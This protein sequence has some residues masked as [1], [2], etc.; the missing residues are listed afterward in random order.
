MRNIALNTAQTDPSIK[1]SAPNVKPISELKD[2]NYLVI[3][4]EE[5]GRRIIADFFV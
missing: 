3:D 2:V 4:N 1:S 5:N